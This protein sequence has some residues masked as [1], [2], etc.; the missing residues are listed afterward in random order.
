[1]LKIFFSL[2]VDNPNVKVLLLN[3]FLISIFILLLK[4]YA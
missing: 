3:T 4:K 2:R 1:M